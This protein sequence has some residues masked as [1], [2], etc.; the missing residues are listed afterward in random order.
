[1]ADVGAVQVELVDAAFEAQRFGGNVLHAD[2]AEERGLEDGGVGELEVGEADVDGRAA[3]DG[4][5]GGG[6]REEECGGEGFEF[7][8]RAV[9][10]E[11]M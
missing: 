7:H 3:V 11:V 10:V 4:G 1:L 6:E 9:F 8:G 2:G 5:A